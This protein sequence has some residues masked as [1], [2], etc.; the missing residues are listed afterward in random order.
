MSLIRRRF[1][2]G[3]ALS[4]VGIPQIG[5]A[6]DQAGNYPDRTIRIIVGFSPGGAPDI[7]ARLIAKELSIAWGQP[8]VVENRTGAGGVVAAQY[9]ANADRKSVV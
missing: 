3:A 8:V 1:L 7:V 2:Q 9:V 5:V 4:F 6:Q